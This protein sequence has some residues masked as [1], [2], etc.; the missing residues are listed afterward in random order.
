MSKRVW[1][2]AAADIGLL[3]KKTKIDGVVTDAVD[4]FVKGDAGPNSKI[5]TKLLENVPCDDLPQVLEGLVP[6]LSSK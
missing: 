6:Y 5:A 2:H 3:G 1:N 4:V